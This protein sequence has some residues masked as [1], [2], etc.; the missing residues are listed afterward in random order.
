MK[1]S[2]CLLEF[3]N[4][5][6]KCKVHG[7]WFTLIMTYSNIFMYYLGQCSGINFYHMSGIIRAT[8]N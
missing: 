3:K 8:I 4:I 7:L 5:D 1:G 6:T 2:V